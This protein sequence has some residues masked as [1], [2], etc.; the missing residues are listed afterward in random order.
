MLPCVRCTCS[1]RATTRYS[2][3]YARAIDSEVPA[4]APTTHVLS[5]GDDRVLMLVN[6]SATEPLES[7][8]NQIE[9]AVMHD[10]KV[11]WLCSTEDRRIFVADNTND[12]TQYTLR[13]S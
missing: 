1:D 7:Y 5:G 2:L 4:F 10:C 9:W 3:T 8:T 13:A 11:N 12:I 6:A